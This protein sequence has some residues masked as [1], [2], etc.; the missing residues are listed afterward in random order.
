MSAMLLEK[1]GNK[2]STDIYKTYQRALL[3]HKRSG[4]YQGHGDRT[5]TNINHVGIPLHKSTTRR[6]IQEI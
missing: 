4:K 5:L 2:S 6:T 1:N 3:F